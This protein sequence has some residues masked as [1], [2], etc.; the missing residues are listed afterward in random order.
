MFFMNYNYLGF[1]FVFQ[2]Y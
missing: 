2:F 1:S